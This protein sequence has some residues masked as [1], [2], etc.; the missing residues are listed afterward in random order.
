MCGMVW[1]M[2]GD[3]LE[4][5]SPSPPGPLSI[6]G[7]RRLVT[8]QT[9]DSQ[10]GISSMCRSRLMQSTQTLRH[11]TSP[12]PPLTFHI[13]KMKLVVFFCASPD[14]DGPTP[15]LPRSRCKIPISKPTVTLTC[16]THIVDF[17][18]LVC[19]CF[20]GPNENVVPRQ[21]RH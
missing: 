9:S 17:D 16:D 11:E 10:R 15:T 3:T 1:L 20:P 14:P 2:H 18:S 21:T 13:L 19:P 8:F 4:S 7:H 6:F 5:P 12:Q